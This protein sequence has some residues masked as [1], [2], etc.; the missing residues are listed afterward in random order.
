[1]FEVDPFMA[2]DVDKQVLIY[3]V[4]MP[5]VLDHMKSGNAVVLGSINLRLS[6]ISMLRATD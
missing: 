3:E 2:S 6:A 1:M 5:T 4:A